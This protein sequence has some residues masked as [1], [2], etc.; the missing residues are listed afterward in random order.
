MGLWARERQN[1]S[2]KLPEARLRI[3]ERLLRMFLREPSW[4]RGQKGV[5]CACMRACVRSCESVCVFMCGKCS[6]MQLPSHARASIFGK[7]SLLLLLDALLTSFLPPELCHTVLDRAGQ[8]LWISNSGG[9]KISTSLS[10]STSPQRDLQ[11][12]KLP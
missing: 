7:L 3:T 1:G 11:L 5:E 12:L 4:R 9:G 6:I 10:P 8:D 2:R